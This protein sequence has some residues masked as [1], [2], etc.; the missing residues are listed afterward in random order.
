MDKLE[1][2]I[3]EVVAKARAASRKVAATSAETRTRA[4]ELI[5][6]GLEE[7]LDEIRELN[8]ADVADAEAAGLPAPMIGRLRIDDRRVRRMF[9]Q[10]G[11]ITQIPD[12]VGAV[13][14][15]V[16]APNGMEVS[17]QRIPLGVLLVIFESRPNAV[18]EI[19]ACAIRSGNAVILRGGSEAKR[20]NQVL[21]RVLG[22][23]LE[24]A[25]LPAATAQ[26]LPM[27]D[28]RAV[29][30][31]LGYHE[32]IDLVIPRGG[33]RLIEFVRDNSKG[34]PVLRHYKGI[35]H[36]YVAPGADLEQAVEI[37]Y[38]SK[39]RA[40]VCNA[41]ETI[42]VDKKVA[43]EFVPMLCANF[44]NNDIEVRGDQET[45]RLGTNVVPATE[46]D[47]STEYL[48]HIV[49][50]AVVDDIEAAIAHIEKYASDHTETIVTNDD[51]EAKLFLDRVNSS[52]V[53]QNASTRLSNL[54][55]F[56]LG[57][58]LGTSTTKLHAYGPMG[59]E[60]LTITKFVVRG[61]GQL[62]D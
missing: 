5:R 11:D 33:P 24:K 10:L 47:W 61:S 16:T 2:E 34:I 25:G 45:C 12:P 8:A 41:V 58:E 13:E 52:T 57:P 36:V 55:E 29:E 28:H 42:L 30:L 48:D 49:S 21:G 3:D 7:S 1:T 31:L 35:C 54:P 43:A 38:N 37:S 20:S 44:A 17:W 50:V 40:D 46:E 27:T 26:V 22:E 9:S 19:A 62:H 59:P 4:L 6:V 14:R 39:S 53:L 15:T 32:D 18:I 56:G 60:A 23:A 51:A